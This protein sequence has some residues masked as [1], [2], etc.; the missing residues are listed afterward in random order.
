MVQ[1]FTTKKEKSPICKAP[2][3]IWKDF[4][5]LKKKNPGPYT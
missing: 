1:K 2:P 4:R 5:K 3:L